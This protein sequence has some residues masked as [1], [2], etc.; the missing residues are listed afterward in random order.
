MRQRFRHYLPLSEAEL[1]QIWDDGVLTVDANVLLDLYRVHE[2]TRDQLLGTLQHFKGRVWISDQAAEEFFRNR[3]SVIAN[4]K[5]DFDDAEQCLKNLEKE[6]GSS[7]EKLRS[8]RLVPNELAETVANEIRP[9]L[10]KARAAL[11]ATSES[12]PNY[13]DTDPLM[14]AVL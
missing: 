4:A 8:L 2:Q 10:A 14:E 1:V 5:K 3:T 7:V 9:T 12:Y 13:L 6:V 11:V